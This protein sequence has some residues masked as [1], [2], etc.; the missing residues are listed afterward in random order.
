[1][2]IRK[3]QNTQTSFTALRLGGDLSS[4]VQY[5]ITKSRAFQKFGQKYDA[6]I[7]GALLQSTSGHM[8]HPALMISDIRPTNPFTKL[9]NY[10]R[11]KGHKPDNFIYFSTRGYEESDLINKINKVSEN[12][13]LK[14]LEV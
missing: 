9:I 1:M 3:I 14:K 12:H 4:E 2:E 5:A 13:L 7:G 6:Y 8:P 10:F 11:N